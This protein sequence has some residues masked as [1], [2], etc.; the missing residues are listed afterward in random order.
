MRWV[1]TTARTSTPGVVSARAS[2]IASSS[3]GRSA[4]LIGVANQSASSARPASVI[5]YG[6]CPP[7]VL[8]QRPHQPVAFQPGQGRVDLPD[9]Q[10]PGRRRWTPRTRPAAGSRT[11]GRVRAGRA[12]RDGWTWQ[13]SMHTGYAL[14]TAVR[15][16]RRGRSGRS[17]GNGTVSG[18]DPG[19]PA[20]PG[21]PHARTRSA[22][23]APGPVG[24]GGGRQ[25]RPPV[26]GRALLDLD[27]QPQRAGP[28][29]DRERQR[30]RRRGPAGRRPAA[31]RAAPPASSRRRRCAASAWRAASRAA[32]VS[33]TPIAPVAR[34]SA[35]YSADSAAAQCPPAVGCSLQR[36][37]VGGPGGGDR[38]EQRGPVGRRRRAGAAAD[39]LAGL[40]GLAQGGE[41]RR[42]AS[43]VAAGAAAAAATAAAAPITRASSVRVRAVRRR[44]SGRAGRPGP[45]WAVAVVRYAARPARA[46]RRPA[47]AAGPAAGLARSSRSKRSQPVSGAAAPPRP[48]RPRRAAAFAGNARMRRSRCVVLPIPT[49][50]STPSAPVR[51]PPASV[52]RPVRRRGRRVTLC[53]ATGASAPVACRHGGDD[54]SPST[55]ERVRR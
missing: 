34:R 39:S 15:R 3:R 4:R 20:P 50:Q 21:G 55:R 7:V 30:V 33:R 38:A 46:P 54:R 44:R 28:V 2:L 23:R 29:G 41:R 26:R 11:S 1:C 25:R 52:R 48:A 19:R 37:Q 18:V 42:P 36:L 51:G 32:P 8:R 22:R 24:A 47:A 53:A 49:G 35:A 5:S 45:G 10:R 9:V 17:P 16:A 40:L 6:R 13:R 14:A 27:G 43:C 31:L 12:G